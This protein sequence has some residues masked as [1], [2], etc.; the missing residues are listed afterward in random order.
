LIDWEN[1]RASLSKV[2][3][4]A[5]K[6]N[7]GRKPFDVVLMFNVTGPIEQLLSFLPILAKTRISLAKFKKLN[8]VLEKEKSIVA[9]SK[10]RRWSS[11]SFE[12]VEYEYFQKDSGVSTFHVG[13]INLSIECG[14]VIFITGGNGAGKS[15]LA[16][17]I[18]Q[19]YIPTTGK[20][21][22]DS[23]QITDLNR[24]SFRQNISC[25]F[26]DYYLFDRI[27]QENGKSDEISTRVRDYIQLLGLEGKVTFKNGK[28][29]TIDLSS[30]QRRRLA[31]VSVLLED[32]QLMLFDE[33]AA[34]QDPEFRHIFYT[35]I[36]PYLKNKNKMVVVITHDD[37]YFEVADQFISMDSRRI[38]I[39]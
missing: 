31:L 22:V 26:S 17:I 34:D 37:R 38:R 7:A 5:R 10:M 13:P 15:T 14:K 35:E 27:L 23:D 11:I 16:K 9:I 8:N 32:K 25:I 29:S 19:H 28:F 4:K 30:G 20:I 39:S 1:F 3:E 33:W 24:N 18:S 12:D 36:L 6:S 2:R 21:W